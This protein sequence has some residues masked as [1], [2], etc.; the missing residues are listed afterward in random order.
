MFLSFWKQQLFIVTA[1]GS[2]DAG[3]W[4]GVVVNGRVIDQR[5]G[6]LIPRCP[7]LGS[8]TS[9]TQCLS[10]GQTQCAK[11]LPFQARG[12]QGVRVRV[13]VAGV[14]GGQGEYEPSAGSRRVVLG[15]EACGEWREA[16]GAACVGTRLRQTAM[17][18]SRDAPHRA[19]SE[20]RLLSASEMCRHRQ[21]WAGARGGAGVG[22]LIVCAVPVFGAGS[23]TSSACIRP[24][25]RP[26]C[27]RERC[28]E[29]CIRA[30]WTIG[31]VQGAVQGV[32]CDASQ[33]PHRAWRRGQES[34][35]ARR[36]GALSVGRVPRR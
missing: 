24:P 25:R 26:T 34:G 19:K 30:G 4:W 17:E 3:V 33:N 5:R 8:L 2:Q 32:N 10:W 18:S 11:A 15:A 29:D 16:C 9:N 12:G 27:I 6:H 14:A 22:L 36:C 35:G 20:R 23:S 21:R 1:H 7:K 31:S 13:R 28:G